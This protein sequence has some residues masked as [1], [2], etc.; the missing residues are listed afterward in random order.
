M[1]HRCLLIL[2][3]ASL[4]LFG[5]PAWASSVF[6][7]MS[8]TDGNLQAW[9]TGISPTGGVIMQ[10]YYPSQSQYYTPYAYPAG[11]AGGTMTNINSAFT[12]PNGTL[13]NLAR[14]LSTAMNASGQSTLCEWTPNKVGWIYSG[15]TNGTATYYTN[16]VSTWTLSLGIDNNGDTCG[17]YNNAVGTQMVGFIYSGGTFNSLG[18]PTNMNEGSGTSGNGLTAIAMNNK[19]QAV[20]YNQAGTV[21]TNYATVWSYSGSGAGF[22]STG[23]ALETGTGTGS[24]ATA[25]NAQYGTTI[26]SSE[27][28][29]VNDSGIVVVGGYTLSGTYS[30]EIDTGYFLYNMTSQQYTPLGSLMLWDPMTTSFS[31]AG[32]HDQAINAAGA[33][34]G[35]TGTQGS[36]WQAAIWQSGTITNLNTEYAS[37]L[38]SGFVL[39]NATAIDNNGDIVGE[40]TYNGNTMQAFEILNPTPE[41]GTLT[42]LAAGLVGL[43]AYG[44]RKRR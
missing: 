22:T 35:Y 30:P 25:W 26:A 28:L 31:R 39:N 34:V 14:S 6:V 24:L 3:V 9:P 40:G 5:G 15:G 38:P 2:A 36:T 29:A 13:S 42:L 43:L 7:N 27:A 8:A 21:A 23:L 18:A 33:V 16:P 10:G 32:G 1:F 4:A 19:G 11:T 41:P 17:Q 44:W 12:Y 37:I 20:G